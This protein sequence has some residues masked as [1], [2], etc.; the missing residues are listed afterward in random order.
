MLICT[1]LWSGVADYVIFLS[2][3]YDITFLVMITCSH[4]KC[5]C[6]PWIFLSI[7]QCAMA[8]PFALVHYVGSIA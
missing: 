7:V 5:A 1:P 8:E 4:Q 2:T 3:L 6:W